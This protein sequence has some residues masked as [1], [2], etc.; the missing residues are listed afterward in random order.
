MCCSTSDETMNTAFH[1]WDSL[2]QYIT[3]RQSL[4]LRGLVRTMLAALN[5]A[6]SSTSGS[7]LHNKF[8]TSTVP[9]LYAWLSHILM[10]KVWLTFLQSSGSGNGSGSNSK[11]EIRIHQQIVSASLLTPNPLT[12]RLAHEIVSSGSPSL[13]RDW[14]PAVNAC[15]PLL[16]EWESGPERISGNGNVGSNGRLKVLEMSTLYALSFSGTSILYV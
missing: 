11:S 4:F 6:L 5:K 13:R 7:P 2:L 16:E 8:S 1:L 14:A 3:Q 9:A 15:L 10:S 12:V